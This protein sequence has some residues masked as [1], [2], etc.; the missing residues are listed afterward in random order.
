M[1]MSVAPPPWLDKKLLEL[2]LRPHYGETTVTECKART[3]DSRGDNY[4][5][6]MHRVVVRTEGGDSHALIIKCRLEEGKFARIMAATRIYRKE[7][8]MYDCTLVRMSAILEKALPG[9][10]TTA[11]LLLLSSAFLYKIQWGS[12][13]NDAVLTIFVHVFTHLQ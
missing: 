7:Q 4:L 5:S 11:R 9:K 8:A 10:C 13:L 12:F 6:A 2:W 3:A 1:K